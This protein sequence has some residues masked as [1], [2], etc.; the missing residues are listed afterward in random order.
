MPTSA[1]NDGLRSR[2]RSASRTLTALAA[3]VESP[4]ESE[5]IF[6]RRFSERRRAIIGP[7]SGTR[8]AGPELFW[9]FSRWQRIHGDIVK[10]G[11]PPT[12]LFL[13]HYFQKLDVQRSIIARFQAGR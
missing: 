7:V 11:D 8:L 5:R 2:N 3:G 4:T 10:C 1:G 12:A 9:R 13:G 6:I